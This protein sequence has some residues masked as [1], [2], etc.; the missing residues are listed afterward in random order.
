MTFSANLFAA[1][2]TTGKQFSVLL[3]N[4]VADKLALRHQARGLHDPRARLRLLRQRRRPGVPAQL[5]RRGVS[6]ETFDDRAR[7]PPLGAAASAVPRRQGDPAGAVRRSTP[8]PAARRFRLRASP[9]LGEAQFDRLAEATWRAIAVVE[10][11]LGYDEFLDLPF[12]V[13]ELIQAFPAVA[14]AAGLRAVDG[15]PRR[16][17][18]RRRPRENRLR[19]PD[20]RGRRQHRLDLGRGARRP[21][22]AALP[23]ARGGVARAIR[24]RIG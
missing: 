9:R 7:R 13:G 15:E 12:S 6:E 20:R 4:C 14:K 24:P 23:R 18:R 3:Y 16:R 2:P 22:H 5:R 10:P 11:A 8:R 17:R 19:P 1:D 21:H